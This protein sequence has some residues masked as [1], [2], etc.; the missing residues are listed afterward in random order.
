MRGAVLAGVMAAVLV[1][2]VAC[3]GGPANTQVT[4]SDSGFSPKKASAK[5]GGI[6][7]WTNGG[8]GPHTV[9]TKDFDSAAIDPGAIFSQALSRPGTYEYICRYHP[10]ETGVVEVR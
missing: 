5:A 9:T 8:V 6:V 3:S 1:V 10:T 2:L 4:I 7:V